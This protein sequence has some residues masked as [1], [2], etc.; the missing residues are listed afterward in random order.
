MSDLPNVSFGEAKEEPED[1]EELDLE[2]GDDEQEEDEPA[3]E[4]LIE[5]LG[6]NPDKEDTEEYEK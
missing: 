3:S 5:L 4:E 6:F 2:D 1:V